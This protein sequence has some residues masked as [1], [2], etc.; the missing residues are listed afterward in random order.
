MLS[1]ILPREKIS[2]AV[3]MVSRALKEGS[4]NEAVPEGRPAV[5]V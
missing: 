3:L 2:I 4:G 1:L 5:W